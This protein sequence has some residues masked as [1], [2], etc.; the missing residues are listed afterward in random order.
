[1][2]M[3]ETV[4]EVEVGPP[5]LSESSKSDCIVE[6]MILGREQGMSA[7]VGLEV[8]VEVKEAALEPPSLVE[9]SK[10]DCTV[11][12]TMSGKV[13]G[14]LAAAERREVRG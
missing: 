4:E 8:V 11:D 1:M 9:N 2:V 5:L 14:M 10:S 12:S 6:S 7:P 3:F 13:R